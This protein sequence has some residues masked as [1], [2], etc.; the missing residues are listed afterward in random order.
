MLSPETLIAW[1]EQVGLSHEARCLID[2]IRSSNPSRPVGGGRSNVRGRYP[3][4]KMGLTIQFESHHVELAGIHEMEHDPSVIEYYDQPQ[5]IKLDYRSAAGKQLGVLHTPDFFVIRT[6]SAGWE[7][8]KTDEDLLKLSREKP[9]RYLLDNDNVWRCPPGEKLAG[10]FGLYYRVRCSSQ[11][12]WIYQRNIQFL[13]DYFRGGSRSLE[14]NVRRTVEAWIAAGC[15]STLE[16]LFQ[17]TVGVVD[18]D[19]IYSLI[20]LGTIEI[21]LTSALLVEP[22]KVR[23]LRGDADS[24]RQTGPVASSKDEPDTAEQ[25]VSLEAGPKS[26]AEALRRLQLIRAY[27]SGELLEEAVPART[28]RY[29][30]QKHRYAAALHGDGLLGLLPKLHQSGNHQS[31]L[32]DKTHELM[33]H[34]I[35]TQYETYTQKN[36]SRVY[37]MLVRACEAQGTVA[38]SFKTFWKAARSRPLHEQVLKRKGP[39]AAYSSEAYYSDL[40]LTTPRHGEWPFHICHVD[41]TELDIE[42]ICSRTGQNL[43]RPWYT[44]LTDAFSRRLLAVFLSFDPPS[45]RSCMMVLRECVRR[46]GRFPQSLVVDGGKEFE[47][48]YFDTLLARFECTKKTRPAAKARFGS[49]CER[50]FGTSNT[51]FIHNLAGNTQITRNIRQVT[52]SVNPKRHAGWTLSEL[53]E[54]LCAWAYEVYETI[55]HPALGQSPRESFA[56]GLAQSGTRRHRA[57]AY[58]EE[59]RLWTL[60]TTTRGT[61]QVV[62]S[63]GVKINYIFYWAPALREPEVERTQ[64]PVRYDPYDAGIAYAYVQKRWLQCISE[65]YSVLRG[66]SERELM[67]ATAELRKRAQRHAGQFTVTAKKLAEFLEGAEGDRLL[68]RQRARDEEAK[69]ALNAGH[70]SHAAR[71]YSS[72]WNIACGTET[73]SAEQVVR[74]TTAKL[75]DLDDLTV[76]EEF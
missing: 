67:L 15:V 53:H 42:L 21:D 62:P 29:W 51:H 12:N 22:D 8:W 52:K 70:E 6:R 56:A 5:P 63:K 76:Y 71:T 57:V 49:V 9:N 14:P 30:M 1:Y 54:S 13:E 72:Q 36:L 2:Q 39:R 4:R 41:H 35:T 24:N 43:G 66:K 27:Q 69:K 65:H 46:H 74:P 34:F 64:V 19:D 75:P 73:S 32:P 59:F 3:S 60:P 28:I 44:M 68:S 38:P 31:R 17:T 7:E 26:M 10:S 20:A 18:R 50:L 40:E 23:L 11:I 16:D 25:I 37:G 48:V 55:P 33:L 47:S 58:D 61:A 45:Y